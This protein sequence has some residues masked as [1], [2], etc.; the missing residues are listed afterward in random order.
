[1]ALLQAAEDGKIFA[2]PLSLIDSSN[3]KVITIP[4]QSTVITTMAATKEKSSITI[5]K[6]SINNE[7]STI[8]VSS[9]SQFMIKPNLITIQ[10]SKSIISSNPSSTA[11]SL[12]TTNV[13]PLEEDKSG[14]VELNSETT[15]QLAESKDIKSEDNILSAQSST[16][17]IKDVNLKPLASSSTSSSNSIKNEN[18][19]E[20]KKECNTDANESAHSSNKNESESSKST[21]V[22][23]PIQAEFSSASNPMTLSSSSVSTSISASSLTSASST[24]TSATALVVITPTGSSSLPASNSTSTLTSSLVSNSLTNFVSATSSTTTTTTTSTLKSISATP[25]SSFLTK[26]AISSSNPSSTDLVTS[27]DFD[28]IKI[29]EWKDGIGALPG[30]NL[31]FKINEFGS[32]EMVDDEEAEEIM[33][34]HSLKA[35]LASETSNQENSSDNSNPNIPV[36]DPN[37]MRICVNCGTRGIRSDFI[38][39]GRFCSQTCATMQSSHLKIF[40]KNSPTTVKPDVFKRKLLLKGGK[41]VFDNMRIRKISTDKNESSSISRNENTDSYE[42]FEANDEVEDIDSNISFD[43][44]KEK[45]SWKE[46]LARIK[47]YCAPLKCFKE[48]QIF[49]TSKNQ[50]KVGMKL[51]GIDP[52]HPSMFC[53]LTVAEVLGFRLRLHFDGYKDIYDFWVNADS[54][55]IFP[56]GWCEK[57]R[58]KLIPPKNYSGNFN[59]QIYLHQT[60]SQAAPKH[61]FHCTKQNNYMTNAFRV[62]MKLEAVDKANSTLVCV[63][64]VADIID[65]WL[66]IHFDGWDD[67]YDYWTPI[68][69]PHIH[70]INWCRSKGRSLTPPKDYHK[71]SERFSWDDYLNET[72][73]I[74]APN[75][76]FRMR[77]GS[78]F[79][80][81]MKLEAVDKLNPRFIRVASVIHRQTHSIKIHYDGW[82]EK[83][84]YW[85]DDDSSDIHPVNWCA[86]TGHLL[87]IPPHYRH[88]KD[89]ETSS[90]PVPGC[91]GLGNVR[92]PRFLTHNSVGGCPYS[93]VNLDKDMPDRLARNEIEEENSHSNN[94]HKTSSPALSSCPGSPTSYSEMKQKR[95]RKR[96]NS[97][98]S[99]SDSIKISRPSTPSSIAPSNNKNSFSNSSLST[100]HQAIF[101]L[102]MNQHQLGEAPVAWEKHSKNLLGFADKVNATEVLQWSAEK[103]AQFVT[104][105][106]GCQDFGQNFEEEVSNITFTSN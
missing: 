45:F 27:T 96:E 74:P 71:S 76:S 7:N 78:N 86:K 69:S 105:I 83:Y 101:A 13:N 58:R 68:N 61:L 99:N 63:A 4:F 11:T 10:P 23:V 88:R 17:L 57:T 46:Y 75:R 3:S 25:S 87:Q 52:Q 73:S 95:K 12:V 35:S 91:S 22:T 100:L 92:G 24:S 28:P 38:R 93:D 42:L 34:K 97:G 90:C 36:F 79:R 65:N 84:D 9:G 14:S 21:S 49:P 56:A 15:L 33:K 66:L 82:D 8:T 70:P 53:V 26:P 94:G 102:R 5:I 41:V 2:V 30:S 1:M 48:N 32:L 104:S 19:R 51:E 54:A 43:D 60:K 80:P 40:K 62:G 85:V 64:T 98:S 31:K 39:Q 103:V 16:S 81:G 106:P 50:F 89:Y 18:L 6:P 59:W 67:S 20:N 77:P 29:M 44:Y 37:E 47:S 55:F 72:K